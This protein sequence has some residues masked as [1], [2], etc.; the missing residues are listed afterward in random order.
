MCHWI[1]SIEQ[2]SWW[3]WITIAAQSSG[4]VTQWIQIRAER[5]K[6]KPNSLTIHLWCLSRLPSLSPSGW[7]AHT[8]ALTRSTF[9]S[10]KCC[11]AAAL[12]WNSSW[13]INPWINAFYEIAIRRIWVNGCDVMR[14]DGENHVAQIPT[15]IFVRLDLKSF[16]WQNSEL[17]DF[18]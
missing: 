5:L 1:K 4:G 16:E 18:T 10:L 9:S 8:Q 17:R 15:I 12:G 11:Y 2:L 7:W 6:P 3:M 13:M 14:L